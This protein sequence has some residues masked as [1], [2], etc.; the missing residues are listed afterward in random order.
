LSAKVPLGQVQIEPS[1]I[2]GE[3]QEQSV[4]FVKLKPLLQVSQTSFEEQIEQ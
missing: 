2:K 4:A 3:E 1:I